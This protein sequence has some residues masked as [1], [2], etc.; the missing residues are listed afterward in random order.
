MMLLFNPNE[1]NLNESS[2]QRGTSH[3]DPET[4]GE[5][6]RLK[7]LDSNQKT[8]IGAARVDT[9]IPIGAR[10]GRYEIVHSLAPVGWA[11]FTWPKT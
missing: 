9:A 5:T 2:T 3:C 1:E 8:E 11:R 4:E 7:Q 6:N 10:L